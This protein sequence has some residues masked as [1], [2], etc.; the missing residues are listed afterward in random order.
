MNICM[1]PIAIALFFSCGSKENTKETSAVLEKKPVTITPSISTEPKEID[2]QTTDITPEI[3]QHTLNTS[4]KEVESIVQENSVNEDKTETTVVVSEEPTAAVVET[5]KEEKET[6]IIEE[7]SEETPLEEVEKAEMPKT[8]DAIDHGP[9]NALLKK[10][11]NNKGNVDYKGFAEDAAALN[12]YLETLSNNAPKDNADKNERLAYYINLYNAATVKLIID[13]YPTKSIKSIK[14][15]WGKKIVPIGDK[16]FSLGDIE[17][18]ILRKM[19]EPRIHFAINCASFSCPKLVNSAFTANQMEEQLQQASID[20]VNDVTR[21]VIS[22]DKIQLSEIF[23]WYK[24][25]FTG[26]GT[27]LKA[28]INQYSKTT[29]SPKAKVSYL[30]Y[31]WSLNEAK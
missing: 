4:E 29:I 1:L 18:K 24:K 17:H 8:L 13:N 7:I 5:S 21:N 15:P 30:K 28:Y 27:S 31:D 3:E 12:S 23:K 26:N 25:D 10:Y 9:W 19:N 20:F 16:K 14:S 6:T 22:T 2:F 11:V